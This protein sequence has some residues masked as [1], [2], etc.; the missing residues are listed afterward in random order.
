MIRYL[1]FKQE[2]LVIA[3]V[4]ASLN[5]YFQ[6]LLLPLYSNDSHLPALQKNLR[7]DT[8]SLQETED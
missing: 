6:Q 7:A 3:G 2:N 4:R 8:R 1:M 5:C